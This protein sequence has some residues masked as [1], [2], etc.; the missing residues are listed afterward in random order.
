MITLKLRNEILVVFFAV[1]ISLSVCGGDGGSDEGVRETTGD[2]VINIAL[3]PGVTPP[4]YGETPVPSITE[5]TQYTGTVTWNPPDSAFAATTVYTA[6]ITLTAKPGY[7]LTGVTT[8]FFTVAGAT[9]DTNS[10][11]T[12]M[13]TAVFP[14]TDCISYSLRD[15][16]PAGGLIFYIN[17]NAATDGWKYLEASPVSTE[18]SGKVWGGFNT[19]VT[20]ADGTAIGT[21]KQNTI[22]I[23]TQFGESEPYE[24]QTE[25]AAKLCSDLTSG[26]Y[27]DWFLPSKDELNFMYT[28]LKK[29]GVGS[30]ADVLYWSSSEANESS[31]WWQQFFSIGAQD[32]NY[33][34]SYS[35]RIRAVRAF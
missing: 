5:T 3:I 35:P 19:I 16:G 2:T 23:V 17:P 24:G 15:I 21:G 9:S 22:D 7:T 34:N 11:D 14:E 25:Y 10:S 28:N 26:G 18:W 8:D 30:F 6:T 13:V 27:D 1:I 4:N 32:Y 33:K 31:A 12:G 29:F 20:G